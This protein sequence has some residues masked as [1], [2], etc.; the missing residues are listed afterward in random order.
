MKKV[1]ILTL[2]CM[3]AVSIIMTGCAARDK[4]E[5]ASAAEE[6][7]AP[8]E[9]TPAEEAEEMTGDPILGGWTVFEGNASLLNDEQ[10]KVFAEATE[11][12]TGEELTPVAVVGTQVVAGM[13][14]EFLCIGRPSV[15]ELEGQA[16]WDMVSV[17][18]D[19]D[20][21]C[22]LVSVKEFDITDP[23]AGQVY[24]EGP[25]GAWECAIDGTC[26]EGEAAEAFDKTSKEFEGMKLTPAVLLGTQVVAGTN[27]RL[28]CVGETANRDYA[29]VATVYEDLD[30][31]A[32]I[33]GC[34][35]LDIGQYYEY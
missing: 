1:L 31:N 3:L 27:Y 34:T 28:L 15:K 21:N 23:A 29:C 20:G 35:V 25:M 13:N 8:A 6:T 10:K 5:E 33:T 30:G 11:A 12:V 14:Y 9:E 19:L 22:E 4:Q 18:V 2:C 24:E 32:E 16:I 17:Y 7:A 26:V